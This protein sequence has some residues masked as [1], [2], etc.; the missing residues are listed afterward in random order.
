MGIAGL[1]KYLLVLG[2]GWLLYRGIKSVMGGDRDRRSARFQQA[3]GGE[4]IDVMVQDPQCGTYLPRE[5][6][7][8]AWAFGRQHYF[9]SEACRDAYLRGPG[10]DKSGSQQSKSREQ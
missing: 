3:G 5:Q 8:K 9:C 1:F 10:P 6:A 2:A 4:V 7:L